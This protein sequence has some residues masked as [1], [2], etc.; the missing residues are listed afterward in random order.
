[1]AAYRNALRFFLDFLSNEDRIALP[2]QKYH[3]AKLHIRF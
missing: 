1:M 2:H 3:T